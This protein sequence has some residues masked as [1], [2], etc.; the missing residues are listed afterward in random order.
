MDA[1]DVEIDDRGDALD[2]FHERQSPEQDGNPNGDGRSAH[3]GSNED[4]NMESQQGDAE[5]GH[6]DAHGHRSTHGDRHDHNGEHKHDTSRGTE[7]KRAMKRD[8]SGSVEHGPSKQGYRR[9]G[10]NKQKYRR[11]NHVYESRMVRGREYYGPPRGRPV[12][13]NPEVARSK[14]WDTQI[15]TLL[16]SFDTAKEDILA[17]A[18]V[19]ADLNDS[20]KPAIATF[21]RSVEAF[22]VKTAAYA[23]VLGILRA[24]KRANLAEQIMQRLLH[25][26]GSHLLAGNRVT[27]IHVLRFLIGAHCSGIT[28]CEVFK[29]IDT[30]INLAKRLEQMVHT[31]QK[32]YVCAT[33][34][35]DNLIYIVMASLPWFSKEEFNKNR[36]LIMAIC[37]E[38]EAYNDR[39]NTKLATVV[40]DLE[41]QCKSA[42][43]LP[44]QLCNP[45]AYIAA[46]RI[47]LNDVTYV[48]RLSSG[49]KCLQSLVQ[50]EWSNVTTYRFYQSKGIAEH[51]TQTFDEPHVTEE[52]SK[53][54]TEIL[55]AVLQIETDKLVAFKPVPFMPLIFNTDSAAGSQISIHDKW[56]FEEH[57]LHTVY[58]FMDDTTLCAKQLLSIPFNDEYAEHAIV[59]ILF[60]MMLGPIYKQHFTLFAVLVMQHMCNVQPKIE[61]VF[62]NIYSQ[63]TD[64]IAMFEPGVVT[65]IIT[66]GAYWFSVEFCKVRKE[67]A[68]VQQKVGMQMDTDGM[69]VED[70]VSDKQDAEQETKEKV[71]QKNEM[72]FSIMFKTNNNHPL[73]FNQ[74]LLDSISRLVYMDR[75]LAF[76]PEPLKESIKDSVQPVP[77]NLHHAL[78]DKTVE[79]R[80]FINLLHFNKLTTEENELR[81]QRIIGFIRN[82]VGKEPLKELPSNLFAEDKVQDIE[83]SDAPAVDNAVGIKTWSRDDLL[84]I[85]WEA[86]LILGNKSLTHLLRLIE[87]HGEVLKNF[88]SQEQSGAFE[89]SAACKILVLTRETL[90]SDTK[91]FE[92]IV[93]ALLRQKIMPP[94]DV[95]R[96]VF[97]CYPTNEFFSNHSFCV[98][99]YAFGLVKTRIEHSSARLAESSGNEDVLQSALE[100]RKRTMH[101]L[102]RTVLEHTNNLLMQGVDGTHEV[103]LGSILRKIM[104][105]NVCDVEMLKELHKEA[106]ERNFHRA[107]IAAIKLTTVVYHV[108]MPI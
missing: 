75:L 100:E 30:L 102:L 69:Q 4:F 66:A 53:V 23:S 87:Y 13:W 107:A 86:V 55:Q 47:Y 18:N 84:L 82:L 38:I 81:N 1:V 26:L 17:L 15:I 9:D 106:L 80:L 36:E 76:S 52:T 7:R 51:I 72:L 68:R 92:L 74:R 105:N 101:D 96:F 43:S 108:Q 41:T 63:I 12:Q 78:R 73:N 35:A 20:S 40:A 29:L 33:I 61:N 46:Y 103:I 34:A 54:T 27:A 6:T 25:N 42:D 57:V 3:D 71:R 50:N 59:E 104:S 37:G 70:T 19:I 58:A 85:F 88:I 93:D 67:R 44:E 64:N 31:N 56:I 49:V 10:Y 98:L 45:Y 95:C 79:H 22:P 62:H 83:M 89:D 14:R 32:D 21:E 48:D 97:R 90:K 16:D 60:N 24:K 8:R 39:R 11:T 94:S 91:K 5:D 2:Q 99:D 77:P 28:S 65:D